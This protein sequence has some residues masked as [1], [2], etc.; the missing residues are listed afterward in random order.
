MTTTNDSMPAIPDM[1]PET[2]REIV[3]GVVRQLLAYYVFPE[4]A[5]AVAELLKARLAAGVY[6][7]LAN[8][9]AFAEQLTADVQSVT[10]DKHL[11]VR[12]IAAGS[13]MPLSDAASAA[14]EWAQYKRL[15]E[16]RNH[17]VERVERLPQNIG[18]LDLRMFEVAA[19]AGEAVTAAMTLVAHTRAL[20][21]DLRH[22]RGG[23]PAT[24]ALACSYLFDE[25]THLNS[26]Y[27]REGDRTDQYWSLDW[28]P[29]PRFGQR[30]P[31]FVLT[32]ERTFSAGEEFA[33]NL[34]CHRRATLIGRRTRGGAHPGGPRQVSAHFEVFVPGGRSINPITQS[35]WEGTGVVP[36][37]DV[38]EED[39]LRVAQLHALKA[40]AAM[41]D[42]TDVE[43]LRERI[44]EL[45]SA[46]G[47][48]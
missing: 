46:P 30:K 37:I 3:E 23:D 31:V 6:D 21:V 38:P 29:G 35:N 22:N 28:V 25:R 19:V 43:A 12:L 17:G 20:I 18:Y 5:A 33:Y 8:P 47:A 14:Q 11:R 44:K 40:L 26:I 24:V 32:S 27:E 45:E 7:S 16:S 10:A 4:K 15:S 2:R 41:P 9:T 39:A 1:T 42:A 13:A 34:Q 36:D 48:A